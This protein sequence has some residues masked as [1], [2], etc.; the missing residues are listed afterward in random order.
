MEMNNYEQNLDVMAEPSDPRDR[1][2]ANFI[3]F[4]DWE[5]LYMAEILDEYGHYEAESDR[6]KAIAKGYAEYLRDRV[7]S[8][9][10]RTTHIK[11]YFHKTEGVNVFLAALDHYPTSGNADVVPHVID[12]QYDYIVER[13]L[14]WGYSITLGD[15][16]E[17]ALAR[18]GYAEDG[19]GA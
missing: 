2:D 19:D 17:E 3:E 16:I 6:R 10:G 15:D 5:A 18:L 8:A 9:D 12:S 4:A 13:A 1:R 14:N 7:R 11:A